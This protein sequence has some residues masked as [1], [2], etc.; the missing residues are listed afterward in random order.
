MYQAR[1]AE[2]Q[3][4]ALPEPQ[5][6]TELQQFLG[7]LTYLSSFIKDLSSKHLS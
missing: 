2:S 5:D 6:K 4:S 1:S 7:M 3:R